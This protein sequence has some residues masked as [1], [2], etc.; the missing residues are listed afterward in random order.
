MEHI[1]KNC[2]APFTG[3]YCNGCG[4]KSGVPVFTFSHIAEEAFHAFTHADKSF[5]VMVKKLFRSPGKVAYEYIVEGKRKKY[6]N[7][8]NF[9][10]IITAVAAFMESR[11]LAI[12]EKIFH[13]NNEYGLLFNVYNKAMS[14]AT[15]PVIALMI[16]LVH[17]KKPRLRYSEYT[18]F[19]MMLFSISSIIQV[20]VKAVNY[21]TVYFFHMYRGLDE[22]I[23]YPILLAVIIAFADYH[24]H[25]QL[26]RGS[27]LQ[28]ILVGLLFCLVLLGIEVFVVWAFLRHFDGLGIFTLYG[29]RISG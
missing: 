12:E 17:Y 5:L 10:L 3:N 15:I 20:I 1:C 23:L 8:F 9:F 24:F 16:W 28:S 13:A 18:V 21:C 26:K 11:Q 19:T 7:P 29:I 2:G 14:L 6:F 25:K 22:Y 4:Q 27:W